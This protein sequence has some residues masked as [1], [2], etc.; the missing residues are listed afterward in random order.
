MMS[1]TAYTFRTLVCMIE[2]TRGVGR[3]TQEI[4][5]VIATVTAGA[6]VTLS[7]GRRSIRYKALMGTG[8]TAG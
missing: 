3:R 6:R 2:L 7:E 5:A 1:I 8:Q 4:A